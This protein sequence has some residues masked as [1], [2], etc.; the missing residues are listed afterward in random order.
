LTHAAEIA[1]KASQYLTMPKTAYATGGGPLT[2][3]DSTLL[4]YRKKLIEIVQ[5]HLGLGATNCLVCNGAIFGDSLAMRESTLTSAVARMAAR[6]DAEAEYHQAVQIESQ[7]MQNFQRLRANYEAASAAW[8]VYESSAAPSDTSAVDAAQAAFDSANTT[9]NLMQ[10]AATGWKSVRSLRQE[11]REAK[12]AIAVLED[13]IEGC[14]A[15]VE[16]I[17][18]TATSA[19]IARVQTFLPPTDT[20]DLVL[21]DGDREVCRF[22]FVR[23]GSLHTALSGAEWAR[24]TLALACAT[25]TDD[26]QTL[27]IFVPEDR[28]FDPHTLKNVLEALS[29]APGQVIIAT[30]TKPAGR[31]PKGWTLVETGGTE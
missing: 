3:A 11:E 22:G 25:S 23:G 1:E 24:L 15:A 13:L 2:E 12:K 31:L 19:F 4:E 18:K 6:S 30:T 7:A 16:G 21:D 28:A 29:D 20:F 17:L 26:P 9:L 10:Q 14:K 5:F 27:R 8:S